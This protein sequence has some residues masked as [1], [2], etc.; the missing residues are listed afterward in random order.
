MLG[1][2]AISVGYILE[3]KGTAV[4]MYLKGGYNPLYLKVW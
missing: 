4:L 1:S 2:A 3:G